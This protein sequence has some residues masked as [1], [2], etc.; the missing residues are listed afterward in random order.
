[1]VRGSVWY[2]VRF[3]Y[4]ITVWVGFWL[5]LEFEIPTLLKLEDEE[6][7]WRDS[8]GLGSGRSQRPVSRTRVRGS[9]H[10][11]EW[12]CLHWVVPWSPSSVSER[13]RMPAA[14]LWSLGFADLQ[15]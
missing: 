8:S 12:S 11:P 7:A 4:S 6:G 9:L 3:K 5:G 15:S 13:M 10:R 1:M 2:M 14:W